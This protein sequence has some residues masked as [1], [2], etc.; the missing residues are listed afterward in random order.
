MG[1]PKKNQIEFPNYKVK[2]ETVESLKKTALECGFKYGDTAA[3][4]AFLD[5]LAEVEPLLVKTILKN[6]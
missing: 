6:I 1:R 2:P 4:G 3:M 5:R